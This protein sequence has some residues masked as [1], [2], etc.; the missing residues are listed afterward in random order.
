MDSKKSSK[1]SI[2][3]KSEIELCIKRRK[4]DSTELHTEEK[5]REITY[6]LKDISGYPENIEVSRKYPLDIPRTR[7]LEQ[8]SYYDL[9]N[10]FQN[11][12]A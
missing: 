7:V 6:T 8:L 9:K 4:I 11:L 1:L 12:S 5:K 3:F 10:I 2:T